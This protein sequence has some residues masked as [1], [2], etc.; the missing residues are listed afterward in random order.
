MTR[1]RKRYWRPRVDP[2]R[3]G[4]TCP[5]CGAGL[6]RHGKGGKR[7]CKQGPVDSCQGV[8]CTCPRKHFVDCSGTLIWRRSP[9]TGAVCGHCGWSGNLRSID[10]ERTYGASRCVATAN[11]CHDVK[12]VARQADH[13]GDLTLTIYC[14]AC[15]CEG[16]VSLDPIDDIYWRESA[17]DMED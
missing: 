15:G 12:V 16:H 8:K 17:A 1:R 5:R 4:L 9:C 13:P 3:H 11:G 7:A 14:S 6:G 10:F 2:L